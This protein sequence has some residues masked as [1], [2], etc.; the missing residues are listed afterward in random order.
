M[1]DN[2]SLFLSSISCLFKLSK[3]III[4][5][6]VDKVISNT[7]LSTCS[8]LSIYCLIISFI[9]LIIDSLSISKTL[10][11]LFFVK[12]RYLRVNLL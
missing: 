3:S 12:L 11:S 5:S 9:N 10:I 2:F 8:H 6:F 7:S 4:L 1:L